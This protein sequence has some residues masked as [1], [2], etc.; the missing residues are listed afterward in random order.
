MHELVR[1]G[2]DGDQAARARQGGLARGRAAEADEE[3]GGQNPGTGRGD[4]GQPPPAGARPGRAAREGWG[5]RGRVAGR[6]GARGGR[7]EVRVLAQDRA[8]EPLQGGPGFQAELA[9][10]HLAGRPV[11]A[12][13]FGLPSAAV[14]GEHQLAV[15]A[16]AQRVHRDQCLELADDVGVTAEGQVGLDPVF[17]RAEPEFLQP[18][19]LHLRERLAAEVAEDGAAAEP[20]RRAQGHGRRSRLA[21]HVR[22]RRLG[23]PGHHRGRPSDG[24]G[25]SGSALEADGGGMISTTRITGNFSSMDSPHS[26]AGT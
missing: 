18:P 2:I 15:Q 3:A 13:R 4:G 12:E 16:L 21:G 17:G 9:D 11:G 14:Q 7:V 22:Q 19:G 24:V 8:L 5:G 6:P 1:G 10:H 25:S 26:A 20:E 23:Q